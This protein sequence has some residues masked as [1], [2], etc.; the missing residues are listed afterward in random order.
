MSL[1]W[2]FPGGTRAKPYL[3]MSISLIQY[4]PECLYFNIRK[5]QLYLQP[6]C[7]PSVWNMTGCS[8]I[9]V[10]GELEFWLSSIKVPTL[11]GA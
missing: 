4:V 8:G 1:A 9:R 5:A 3:V 10:F 11:I 7:Q 6:H 2:L